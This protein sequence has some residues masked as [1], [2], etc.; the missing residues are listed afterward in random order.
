MTPFDVALQGALAWVLQSVDVI[1]PVVAAV[2]VALLGL[3]IFRALLTVI[4]VS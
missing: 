2:G 1:L 4:G 3:R